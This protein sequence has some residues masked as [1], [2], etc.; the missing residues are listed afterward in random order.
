M[1]PWI[2][3]DFQDSSAGGATGWGGWVSLWGD[4]CHQVLLDFGTDYFVCLGWDKSQSVSVP[5]KCCVWREGMTLPPSPT[6]AP[7]ES[8]QSILGAGREAGRQEWCP[9]A[10]DRGS[11]WKSFLIVLFVKLWEGFPVDFLMNCFVVDTS[12]YSANRG[13]RLIFFPTSFQPPTIKHKLCS[14]DFSSFSS[15]KLNS[16]LT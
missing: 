10:R 16:S 8:S 5:H 3:W 7:Q 15:S 4:W 13:S 2:Y 12:N 14:L 9:A 6:P 1:N 11:P